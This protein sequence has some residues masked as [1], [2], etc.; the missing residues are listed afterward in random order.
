MSE[1]V[2]I[3]QPGEDV[4]S[5]AREIPHRLEIERQVLGAMLMYPHDCCSQV[6]ALVSKPEAFYAERHGLVFAAVRRIYLRGDA[7]D[8]LTVSDELRRDASLDKCG[9]VSYL[10]D[11]ANS[12]ISP[13]NIEQ[14][15]RLLAEDALRREV[16]VRTGHLMQKAHSYD[17]DV[18][19]L[20]EETSSALFALRSAL[21]RRSF[22]GFGEA[23]ARA[24]ARVMEA[25]QSG[26]R[27]V[28]GL[29]TGYTGLNAM[30]GGWQRTDMLI[31]AA[32]PSMG[33]TALALNIA[34]KLAKNGIGV[35]IFS[36]EMSLEQ[37]VMRV[38]CTD[39]SVSMH[40]LRT[41]Y[42]RHEEVQRLY[43]GAVAL[44]ELPIFIDDTPGITPA[45]LRAKAQ[46]MVE[47][48]GVQFIIV[49]YLQL[50]SLDRHI[51]SRER[52]V[53][54][55]SKSLKAVAKDMDVPA[56]V[57]SQLS[58]AVESRVGG[59]PMLSDLRESGSI[60]QDADV[61]MFIHRNRDADAPIADQRSAD[62]IIAK[63]R[64]GMTG[65]VMLAWDGE[66]MRFD[67]MSSRPI[68]DF[69]QP[70]EKPVF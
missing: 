44:S 42:T 8:L 51:D 39:C 17:N 61:V 49:D 3:W 69:V 53:A 2:S 54:M 11:L 22:T 64:N 9:G 62:V 35:G 1:I 23:A 33:K 66:T 19:G 30:L 58:R 56:L 20:L 29:D 13:A 67:D 38:L 10:S 25:A 27:G 45:E 24:M 36:L 4:L 15:T 26:K 41:G 59:R 34:L 6:F 55:I 60:E 57:L 70:V 12:I 32:R 18:F 50:M 52:E 7:I 37:V 16:I 47:R 43:D 46:Q 40:R 21:M 63:Q 5:A 14:H 28:T 31:L 68:D 65:N 48:Y